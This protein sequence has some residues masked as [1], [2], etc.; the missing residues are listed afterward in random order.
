[1]KK[2]NYIYI[3]ILGTRK[4]D[5]REHKIIIIIITTTKIVI[6]VLTRYKRSAMPIFFSQRAQKKTRQ[7]CHR[8][9]LLV[10]Y[11]GEI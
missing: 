1:M 4:N 3:Y 6:H 7:R 11:Y 9:E 10:F 5:E 2:K 8:S